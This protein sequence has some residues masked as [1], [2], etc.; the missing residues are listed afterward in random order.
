MFFTSKI[1]NLIVCVFAVDRRKRTRNQNQLNVRFFMTSGDENR[2]KCILRS[3]R[4]TRNSQY[5][6]KNTYR[7][8]KLHKFVYMFTLNVRQ[9]IFFEIIS[10]IV[11][12]SHVRVFYFNS[13]TFAAV[14][15][16]NDERIV[17]F[18]FYLLITRIKQ[19][20][21]FRCR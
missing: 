14:P 9:L 12:H 16:S 20:P 13:Q 11:L 4:Y 3:K 1:P 17:L 18:S 15:G 21:K 5:Y 2:V 10:K 19:R 8:R 6:G 7:L